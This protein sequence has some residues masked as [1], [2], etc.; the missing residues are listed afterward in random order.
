VV[1]TYPSNKS[2]SQI[3]EFGTMSIKEHTFKFNFL[4]SPIRDFSNKMNNTSVNG[5]ATLPLGLKIADTVITSLLFSFSI[6]V[7]VALILLRNVQP[8]RF[9][10]FTAL[11]ATIAL[12]ISQDVTKWLD[13]WVPDLPFY[14]LTIRDIFLSNPLYVFVCFLICFEYIRFIV[15]Q[16][17]QAKMQQLEERKT[18]KRVRLLKFAASPKGLAFG[19]ILL[20]IEQ[21][22]I[23]AA[24][25]PPFLITKFDVRPA[26]ETIKA[27]HLVFFVIAPIIS[28][29]YQLVA[30]VKKIGCAACY[31]FWNTEKDP[32]N[33]RCDV[34]IVGIVAVIIFIRISLEQ[35]I[36]LFLLSSPVYDNKVIATYIVLYIVRIIERLGLMS[37]SALTMIATVIKRQV[38]FVSEEEESVKNSTTGLKSLIDHTKGR[39]MLMSYCMYEFSAENLHAYI[40]IEKYLLITNNSDE[41]LNE[42]KSIF[43]EFIK[44]GSL[45]EVNISTT[46]RRDVTNKLKGIEDQTISRDQLADLFNDFHMEVLCNLKDSFNRFKTTAKYHKFRRG[47]IRAV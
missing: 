43:C 40:A 34:V 44:Q 4:K 8:L 30:D 1:V 24:I 39:K 26:L 6:A 19:L 41:K 12:S 28:V 33:Y 32:L 20:V 23:A 36:Q 46:V 37:C 16:L 7:V 42:A 17:I 2:A 38:F 13:L 47:S 35:T 25:T 21:Y 27:A 10:F 15:N 14:S 29:I 3:S 22:A 9:R 18:S 11:F 31:T 5:T 45:S